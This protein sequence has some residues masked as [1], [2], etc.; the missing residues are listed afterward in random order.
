MMALS[1]LN[2]AVRLGTRFGFL[3]AFA[4]TSLV[5]RFLRSSRLVPGWLRTWVSGVSSMLAKTLFQ[6]STRRW[7]SAS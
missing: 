4:A 6:A 3:A 5:C 1:T 7:Y 2:F